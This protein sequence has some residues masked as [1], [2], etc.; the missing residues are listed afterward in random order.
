MVPRM[1]QSL[2]LW[3]RVK[4]LVADVQRRIIGLS[5]PTGAVNARRLA[6]RGETL[7]T[8]VMRDAVAA[9][10]PAL[11]ALH[12]TLWNRTYR[13]RGPSVA[14]RLAQW[15]RL[16]SEGDLR[17]FVLVLEDRE[18]RIIGFARGGPHDGPFDGELN[19]IYLRWEY[20][21]LG[22]GRRMM[23]EAA[24]RFLD[25]GMRSFILFAERSN[26][27]IGFYDRLG[28][29]RLRDGRGQFHGAYAWR[30]ARTLLG[31]LGTADAK[32]R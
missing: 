14:T 1:P 29:E 26:P 31:T 8:I 22:L 16:F 10:T 27:T 21:G 9:D 24:R 6:E 18:R 17:E 2:S 30:D 13:M 3:E 25:R 23:A 15:N 7:D 5:R 19:K 11:A 4:P 32:F 20:H 12:V 28:G